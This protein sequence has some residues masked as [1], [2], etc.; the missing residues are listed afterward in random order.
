M[1]TAT[2][3]PTA[4][5]PTTRF[6]GPAINPTDAYT[7]NTTYATFVPSKPRNDED[8]HSWG[9][10]DFSAIPAGATINSVTVKVQLYV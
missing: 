6:N 7:D 2:K 9:G 4:H 5:T 3:Y 8:A 1:A 10:F